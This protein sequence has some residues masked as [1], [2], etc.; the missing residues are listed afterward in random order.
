MILCK[1][2]LISEGILE[3][4]E[5]PSCVAM[6]SIIR[7]VGAI[8]L[9]SIEIVLQLR[10]YA[11]YNRSWKVKPDFFYLHHVNTDYKALRRLH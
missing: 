2:N 3:S 4:D 1:W 9:C 10:I 6:D 8:S 11:L 7:V 5:L